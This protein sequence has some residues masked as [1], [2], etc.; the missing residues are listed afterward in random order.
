MLTGVEV[1]ADSENLRAKLKE[2]D[3]EV[4]REVDNE[5]DNEEST[6]LVCLLTLTRWH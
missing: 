3:R 6:Y 2:V 5:V 4:D 1:D